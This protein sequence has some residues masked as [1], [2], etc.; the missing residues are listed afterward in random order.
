MGFISIDL[1][2]TNIK[3]A[4]FDDA[5]HSLG[6]ESVNVA[7][8]RDGDFVEFAAD[9][10]FDSVV[11]AVQHCCQKSFPAA[12]YPI[13]QI[14]LTGQAESLI[15]L[16]GHYKPIRSAISWLDMRSRKECEELKRTFDSG[17]CYHITGQP[18]IIPTWPITKILWLRKNEPSTHERARH[19]VLLKD[20]IQYRLTGVLA[21]EFSI[22]NFSYY[23]NIIRKEYWQDILA[24]CGVGLDQLPPLVAPCTVLG[25]LKD[26]LTKALAISPGCTI[27]VGT[28]DHFA[29]MIGT[30]NIREGVL[31]ES[32]GTVLTIA[33]MVHEP[34]FSDM[35]VALHCG[36][37]PDSYVLLPVCESG[38]ISLEWFKNNFLP[39]DS[40]RQ[41]DEEAS[42]KAI[43]NELIFL[44]YITGVNAPDFNP[45]AT[46]VFY[47][48]QTKHDRFDFALAVM[49]GVAHLLKRNI[50]FIEQAGF[51]T[52]VII[53][54]G[55]GAKSALWSQMKADI[56][57]HTIAIPENE[58]AAC[59]GAAMIGAVSEGVF[60]N[61]EDAVAKSVAIKKSYQA[62]PAEKY[63]N[64][65]ALF[66][67]L[68]E[69]VL[70][71]FRFSSR[72]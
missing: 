46:G 6:L 22:Y 61:Y 38:G 68:L 43:P 37:F 65:H 60:S 62:G 36:P 31:S 32:T 45:D 21:G 27:N 69:Q 59:L 67:L 50:D 20:Y 23:F 19:F 64:K 16:D 18:E 70:P 41:I 11:E 1:G 51:R 52:D 30:G 2:T 40:Y 33:T 47:G 63:G 56:T 29:G 66:N 57:Q 72:S 71:V 4:A 10:Y 13:R 42:K 34:V 54:T 28:L 17:N 3:V 24:H 12:P 49:E 44:P 39:N 55:G 5:L 48:I 53:S 14:I 7:Y 9:A 58:E 8:M 35:H 25:P 15:V 26:D